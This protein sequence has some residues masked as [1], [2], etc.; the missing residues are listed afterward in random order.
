MKDIKNKD[1]HLMHGDCIKRVQEIPE[2]HIK[3]TVTSPPYDDLRTYKGNNDQWGE[4]SWKAV[5]RELYRVTQDGG[6]VVWVVGDATIEGSETGTSFKQALYAMECGFKLHDTMIYSR[7]A[8][9][10]ASKRYG[11]DFEYMFV[12]VKGKLDTFNPKMEACKYAGVGTS[13]TIRNK[14]GK[15]VGNG[16]R[17]IKDKKKSSN[18]WHYS[19]GASKSTKDK[20]AHKHPAIFPESLAEDHIL[21][22]SDEGDIV[23]DPFAGSGTTGKMSLLNKRKFIGIELEEEYFEIA[24]TRMQDA[25]EIVVSDAEYEKAIEDLHSVLEF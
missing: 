24:H 5:L 22:W 4:N 2:N 12:L 21:T 11:Q 13:P 6:V 18:I 20:I 14:E 8:M 1:M 17:T 19:A 9:P 23:F 15:L 7:Y 3:L 25:M 10:N 16:R